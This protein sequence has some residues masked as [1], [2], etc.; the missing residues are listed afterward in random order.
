[1][2]N[3]TIF[4]ILLLVMVGCQTQPDD[5]SIQIPI[6]MAPSSTL[7]GNYQIKVS[8]SGADMG[9]ITETVPVSVVIGQA[10]TQM[11]TISAVPVGQNRKIKIQILEGDQVVGQQTKTVDLQD[12]SSNSF[13]FQFKPFGQQEE[14]ASSK[15]KKITWEKDGK[16]MVLIPAGS[17]EM[18]DH[19]DD[20]SKAV[21]VHTVTLD[22]FYMDTHEVTVGQFREFVNQSGYSYGVTWN[23]VAKYSPGDDYPMVYVSWND[24]TAY[25]EWAGKRLPTEAEWEYAARGGLIGQRYPWGDDEKLARDY[26]NYEGTG[27]K[28][29]WDKTT[30]PVGSFEANGY[31][32][33]DMAG[34][35]VEWCQDWYDSDYYTNS[36]VSNPIGPDNGSWKVCR[37]GTWT[38]FTDHLRLASRTFTDPILRYG[39]NG[40]RCVSGSN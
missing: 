32:L 18:G 36:P 31:G 14:V 28:D 16:E 6:M 33:Y 3:L 39:L 29:K 19:L 13:S 25:A 26:A 1:M 11:V 34:N 17:F 10:Q 4:L 22:T 21:P 35:V 20:M 37:G 23:D 27:G 38:A 15:K 12:Q 7:E 2:K 9:T 40:F 8:I 30:A 24:A 5:V